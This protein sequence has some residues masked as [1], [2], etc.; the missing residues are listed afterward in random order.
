MQILK[1]SNM[2]IRKKIYDTARYVIEEMGNDTIKDYKGIRS[3]GLKCYYEL[4]VE[5][6]L[7][8][9]AGSSSNPECAIITRAVLYT[10][11]PMFRR[12]LLKHLNDRNALCEL[13]DKICHLIIVRN[14]YDECGEDTQKVYEEGRNIMETF[15][16]E[17]KVGCWK[18]DKNSF[19]YTD[20]LLIED[21]TSN[22]PTI[23][24]YTNENPLKVFT[25]FSGYDSQCLALKKA[26]IPFDLIGWSE[27][28]KRAIT[29]HN[30]LFPEYKDRNYG[31]ICKIDW[32]NVPDFDLFTYSS[33]CQSF[34]IAGQML[35]G[36]E[37]SGT[38]SSLLWECKKAIEI[39]RPKYLMLENVEMLVSQNFIH[40]F[41][42]WIDFL[43]SL[44]YTSYWKVLKGSD[45]GIPQDRSRIF[46]VSIL[47]PTKEFAF[48][49][50]KRLTTST[51]DYMLTKDEL[52]H[53][54]YQKLCMQKDIVDNYVKY[55]S[56]F[57]Q[58]AVKQK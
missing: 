56:H 18:V 3:S 20:P 37:G 47:N 54:L 28:E 17:R 2:T 49:K 38:K 25:T 48:P 21:D 11:L 5:G 12:Y 16:K 26:G 13:G 58:F 8:L 50:A 42:K 27:I 41:N 43:S 22:A 51:E 45:Y 31:D 36:D 53:D 29:A 15:Y 40:T 33:P 35:G 39:K 44:G 57:L 32:D 55:N 19:A 46:V 24:S 10:V 7:D 14:A 34:S 23:G 52:G 4:S 6:V 9:N 30:A 1:I